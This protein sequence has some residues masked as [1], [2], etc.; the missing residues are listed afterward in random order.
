MSQPNQFGL[1]RER[2]FL[3]FFLTQALGAFNDNVFKNALVILVAFRIAGLSEAQIGFYA[4]LAAG[5]FI[6]PFFLFSANAGQWAEKYEK[7]ALIRRVKLAE[8]L[9]MALGAA[10]F[11]TGSLPLLLGVLFLMGAQSAIFGP[12]KY[13]LLPQHLRPEELVGGN[14]WVEAGTFLAIL[15]GT[16]AGG[17]LMT[18]VPN[19]ELWTSVAVLAMAVLGWLASRAIPAAPPSAPGLRLDWNP[20]TATWHNLGILKGR[21]A[22]FNAVLGVSWF[23]FFGSVFIAQLPNYTRIFLGGNEQVASLV[24]AVFSVGI[25]LGSLLCERMSG[26]KIEIG[27]VPFGA[28]GLTLFG[29]DLYFARPEAAVQTGLTAAQ[30][31]AAPGTWRILADLL[32]IGLFGGFYIVPL[33]ALIQTRTPRDSVARVISANN[34]LNAAFMVAAAG[35]AIA[36]LDAGLNIPQLLLATA[37]LN[38]V[39]AVYIFTLVPEFLMRFL[40]WM[41]ISVL[42]RVRVRGLDHVPDDGP[43]LLVCN[44][45]SYVDALVLGGTIRRP[46]RFVMYYKIFRIPVLSWIF[47]TARAIPIAG[48]KEDP[49]LMEQAFEEIDRALAAGEIVGIFPEGALTRDGGIAPFRSGVE[50]ILARR[51]VPVVPMALTGLWE[52]MWSRRDSALRRA[53]LPRRLRARI[54]VEIGAPV[55]GDAATAAA[56]EAR[57]RA[58]RG[59]NC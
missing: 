44:H 9:I 17:L 24:L 13:A 15:L 33:F 56:L 36:L 8:I 20:F 52:S 30:F 11:L 50:R 59:G 1:L 57:V 2:R 55:S 6:L 28:I 54:G 45:V 46:V 29:V 34:I 42:Y 16:L 58:L 14:A 39:V 26:H 19:G 5:L 41:L 10:G 7:A 35:L 38:A 23:W 53:R 49:A 18:A 21:R 40:V 37:L 22:V 4:N 31:L 27:L 25:G 47:R 48:A 51:P 32:L 12:L 3:P 43:A